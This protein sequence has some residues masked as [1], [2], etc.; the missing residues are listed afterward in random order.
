MDGVFF[1][2]IVVGQQCRRWVSSAI[3]NCGFVLYW[4]ILQSL[5][6][7]N[8]R[9][10]AMKHDDKFNNIQRR[11]DKTEYSKWFHSNYAE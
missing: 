9:K 2:R 3:A 6:V 4:F 1:E 5:A 11:R 10:I 7:V 8:N